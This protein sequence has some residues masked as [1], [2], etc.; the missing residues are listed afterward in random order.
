MDFAAAAAIFWAIVVLMLQL[1]VS[2]FENCALFCISRKISFLNY[3]VCPQD[4]A[5]ED[6]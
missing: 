4:D 1:T 5:D 6:Y 3:F 2:R